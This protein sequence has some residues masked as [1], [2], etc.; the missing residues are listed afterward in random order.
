MAWACLQRKTVSGNV[1]LGASSV[2]I[3]RGGGSGVRKRAGSQPV[4][5]AWRPELCSARGGEGSQA[6]VI[7]G[8]AG[9]FSFFTQ[10]WLSKTALLSS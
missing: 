5:P 9:R 8:L 2:Q 1:K 6:D 3:P 4:L 10:V 7:W